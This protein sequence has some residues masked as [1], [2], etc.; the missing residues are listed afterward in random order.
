MTPRAPGARLETGAVGAAPPP[1]A[2]FLA[3]AAGACAISSCS[4]LAWAAGLA[5]P[6]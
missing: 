1:R 4:P 3:A 6:A 5:R 2:P